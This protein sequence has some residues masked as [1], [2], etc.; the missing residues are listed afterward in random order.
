MGT[1][2]KEKAVAGVYWMSMLS[3]VNV[4]M[5]LLI[6][7]VL[8]RLLNSYDFGAVASVQIVISFA[9]IFWMLGVGPAIVQKKQLTNDDVK[10]GNTLNI[11]FGLLIYTVIFIFAPKIAAFIGIENIIMLRVLA[12]VFLI[13]S[14]SSVSESLLQ[15]DM[16]FRSIGLINAIALVGYGV[17]ATLLALLDFGAWAL[18]FAQL[19]QVAIK[20]TMAIIK[21]PIRM[22]IRVN[23]K[24]AKE[25]MFFG[26]GFTLS[27]IF[28]SI[29][30][31]GDYFVVNRTLGS[32]SLGFYNRAYQ[33]LM[34]PTNVISVVLDQVLFPLLSKQQDNNEKL[35][36]V[37]VNITALVSLI[38]FPITIISLTVGK[39]LVLVVLGSQWTETVVPFQIL[40]ISLFFRMAYKICDSLVRSLGA[41][42]KRMWVQIVYALTV[43]VGALIG[44]E[45]GLIGVA[46]AVTI[47]ISLN[48]VLM[49]V[50]IMFLIKLKL[51]NLLSYL[52]PIFIVSCI[53]GGI[54]YYIS[55]L[56]FGIP[57]ALIKIAIITIVV[58]FLYFLTLK[59]LIFKILPS[60]FLEFTTTIVGTTMKKIVPLKFRKS[61]V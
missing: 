55:L 33:L 23:K 36:Y 2:L 22:S 59:Y 6:T 30:L 42:Y 57:F 60:D 35:R 38:A 51:T 32:S 1:S 11:L 34:V 19:F 17:S 21:R 61:K 27:K 3:V 7:M 10:T 56:F 45:W 41:I 16:N 31:Q 43:I 20:T 29:A 28:N 8:S 58:C 47:A 48:Y 37:F 13:H 4:V 39:E 44:K 15:K 14:L 5:K 46:I 49:T 24:S 9:D 52:A 12:I 53:I 18:I 54:V 40:V 50:L 26:T 25:L